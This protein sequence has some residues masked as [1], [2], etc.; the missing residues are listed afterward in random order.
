[1]SDVID[2][3]VKPFQY[4]AFADY[5]IREHSNY[6]DWINNNFSQLVAT[7]IPEAD[8]SVDY[9]CGTV[10]GKLPLMS[11]NEHYEIRKHDGQEE[12]ENIV[13][14]LGKGYKYYLFLDHYYVRSS[15][16]F[17]KKH[18]IHDVL[19]ISK[20]DEIISF[21][22]NTDGFIH[23]FEITEG[24]FLRSYLLHENYCTFELSVNNEEKYEFSIDRFGLMIKEYTMGINSINNESNYLSEKGYF[25]KEF[26]ELKVKN[27]NSWGINVYDNISQNT[28]D[29]ANKKCFVD[30]RW[31]YLMMERNENMCNKLKYCKTR[32]YIGEFEC[33]LTCNKLTIIRNEIKK[34]MNKVIKYTY[35]GFS[36]EGIPEVGLNMR[37][38]KSKE[39]DI[40]MELLAFL[41]FR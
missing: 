29:L 24:E 10:Y 27:A 4:N 15:Q 19:V 34:N 28:I 3:Y 37:E 23:K 17:E 40:Y 1:M 11:M 33:D 32:G 26:Y 12:Y 41:N 6:V 9:F 39:L 18:V 7:D 13:I 36:L 38:I 16:Y 22:E 31:F 20:K 8:L 25:S 21:L 2:F 30:Y 5:V 35:S 14:G